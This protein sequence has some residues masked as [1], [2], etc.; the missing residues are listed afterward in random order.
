MDDFDLMDEEK[1]NEFVERSERDIAALREK[2]LGQI[3]E[4]AELLLEICPRAPYGATNRRTRQV[5]NS[6]L[7]NTSGLS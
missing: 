4:L 6:P 1:F 7:R 2:V 3:H 5:D